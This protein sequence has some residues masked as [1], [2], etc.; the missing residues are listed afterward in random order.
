MAAATS[1]SLHPR[2]DGGGVHHQAGQQEIQ[3]GEIPRGS[4]PGVGSATRERGH[5]YCHG[6]RQVHR[7]PL[8]R[9]RFTV[10]P[11]VSDGQRGGQKSEE[12][13]RCPCVCVCVYTGV[14]IE[15]LP[16][17]FSPVKNLLIRRDQLICT[18]LCFTGLGGAEGKNQVTLKGRRVKNEAEKSWKMKI[19]K[20][21]LTA[22]K[23]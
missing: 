16:S 8:R 9:S 7:C 23:T 18:K 17:T 13:T 3:E 2:H 22:G 14:C 1:S 10:L 21:F 4:R 6:R 5:H 12:G 19:L 11:D 15:P 20:K